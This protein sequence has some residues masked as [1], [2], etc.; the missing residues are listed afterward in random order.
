MWDLGI[1]IFIAICAVSNA[2][3]VHVEVQ[4]PWPAFSS[5]PLVEVAEYLYDQSTGDEKFWSYVDKICMGD[6]RYTEDLIRNGHVID[7]K[8]HALDLLYSTPEEFML[9]EEELRVLRTSID[10]GMYLPA[11]RMFESI[12]A[13]YKNPCSKNIFAVGFRASHGHL[14]CSEEE[15]DDF[16]DHE[17]DGYSS[18]DANSEKY[19]IAPKG[20]DDWDHVYRVT[21]SDTHIVVYGTLGT[22]N[23]CS[24]HNHLKKLDSIK[25]SLRH[26]FIDVPIPADYSLSKE[27][28]GLAVDSN[29]DYTNELYGYGVYLD[30][31]NMEYKTMDDGIQADANESDENVNKRED[32]D[33][34]PE[35]EE[36][37]GINFNKLLEVYQDSK[38]L[39]EQ[40]KKG[41]VTHLVP[42]KDELKLFRKH[43]KDQAAGVGDSSGG[44]KVWNLKD[45][46]LQAVQSVRQSFVKYRRNL[47]D[48]TNATDDSE[49]D[50]GSKLAD[51]VQ[52]FP[53]MASSLSTVKP[54]NKLR[55]EIESWYRGGNTL[56]HEQITPISRALPMNNVFINGIPI[57]LDSPTFNVYDLISVV[58]NEYSFLGKLHEYVRDNLVFPENISLQAQLGNE[59]IER[60]TSAAAIVSKGSGDNVGGNVMGGQR[61]MYDNPF[62]SSDVV[63]VDVSKGGKYAVHFMNNLEKDKMYKSWPKTLRTLVTPS[64]NLHTISRNLYTVVAIIQPLSIAGSSMLVQM[65]SLIEDGMPIRFGYVLSCEDINDSSGVW[66]VKSDTQTHANSA[67][68]DASAA[69]ATNLDVCVLYSKI[70]QDHSLKLAQSFLLSLASEI[71]TVDSGEVGLF[72]D[73]FGGGNTDSD[74]VQ[75]QTYKYDP[76]KS[77]NAVVTRDMV[78]D[79]YAAA[80]NKGTGYKQEAVDTII[81]PTLN[82]YIALTEYAINT[83]AYIQARGLSVNLCT[84][85]GVIVGEPGHVFDLSNALMQVI[86][87]EQYILSQAVARRVIND[88]TK[89]IF[90]A[91]LEHSKAFL[92]YHPMLASEDSDGGQAVMQ[93]NL[94][95]SSVPAHFVKDLL[96]WKNTIGGD[97]SLFS[98]VVHTNTI[99]IAATPNQAGYNS[100]I[101]ALEWLETRETTSHDLVGCVLLVPPAVEEHLSRITSAYADEDFGKSVY[102]QLNQLE[103]D[104][105]LVQY[106][107]SQLL[108]VSAHDYLTARTLR[109]VFALVLR[110]V[111]RQYEDGELP[112]VEAVVHNKHYTAVHAAMLDEVLNLSSTLMEANP[113]DKS[114]E[115]LMLV[116]R[117]LLDDYFNTNKP[118]VDAGLNA[119]SVAAVKQLLSSGR[120]MRYCHVY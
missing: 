46:G 119:F 31:K 36:V 28:S 112:M 10:I 115:S 104:M 34:F 90:S 42:L 98:S 8:K 49:F 52:N 38:V 27:G 59:L 40:K 96:Y 5:S 114:L 74:S 66:D 109:S 110:H 45:L 23:L 17:G 63:R 106:M 7:V 107:Q 120:Y 53:A 9:S 79:Y 94:F 102:A 12:A 85:N 43:L 91:I 70:K 73:F 6:V 117:T 21:A 88:Q 20:Y 83:T 101:S 67:I 56:N 113:E 19:D 24:M 61:N 72:G 13:P 50:Y 93:M 2:R 84:F 77:G 39:P 68:G 80:I 65:N 32:E 3:T 82:A 33:N 11:V 60:V 62:D 108:A 71:T 15:V 58:R 69:V 18:E 29:S 54:S 41:K 57:N 99:F 1:L 4:A 86:G 116:F 78:S 47:L 81:N 44:M 35:G 51:I 97:S 95:E 105:L 118:F 37:S 92:R 76:E 16:L 87:R 30:I 22:A 103:S 100:I 55:K 48:G 14:L 75:P 25:Y 89:S 111:A 26:A 64:W